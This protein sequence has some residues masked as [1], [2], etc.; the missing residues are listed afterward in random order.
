MC[1]SFVFVGISYDTGQHLY[2]L[3]EHNVIIVVRVCRM[4]PLLQVDVL[5]GYSIGISASGHTS[6]RQPP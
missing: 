2:N 6:L 1:I 3:P 4:K 5:I